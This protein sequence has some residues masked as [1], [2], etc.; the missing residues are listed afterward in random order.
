MCLI[1][2]RCTEF[3]VAGGVIQAHLYAPCDQNKFPNCS[4]IYQSSE[5][6]KCKMTYLLNL[7]L[8]ILYM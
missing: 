6:Y 7:I 3:N 2:G 8:L 5:A 1:L 4:E